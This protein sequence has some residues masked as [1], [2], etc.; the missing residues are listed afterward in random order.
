MASLRAEQP[1]NSDLVSS[2]DLSLLQA[3]QIGSGGPSSLLQNG[4]RALFPRSKARGHLL[5]A[6]ADVKDTH[7]PPQAFATCSWTTLPLP[8]RP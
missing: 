4:H 6:P 5:L 8:S 3:V 1:T 2:R 7:T